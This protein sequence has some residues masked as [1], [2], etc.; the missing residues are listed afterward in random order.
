MS[1][2]TYFSFLQIIVYHLYVYIS[3]YTFRFNGIYKLLDQVM[4]LLRV[5]YEYKFLVQE[6]NGAKT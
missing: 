6:D 5:T 3:I 2:S 1:K 4:K